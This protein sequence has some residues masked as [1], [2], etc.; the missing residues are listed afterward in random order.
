MFL[1]IL[2]PSIST[3]L[4][5]LQS[6]SDIDLIKGERKWNNSWGWKTFLQERSRALVNRSARAMMMATVIASIKW[7]GLIDQSTITENFKILSPSGCLRK[8]VTQ[9]YSR[10]F[11]NWWFIPSER[12][13]YTSSFYS[14]KAFKILPKTLDAGK[15]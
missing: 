3:F 6:R 8:N 14:T 7:K 2:G 12:K 5:P 11:R 1:S 15:R 9:L 4:W 10:L 13:I